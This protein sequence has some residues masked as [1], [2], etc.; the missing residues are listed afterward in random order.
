MQIDIPDQVQKILTKLTDAGYEACVVGGCVRDSVMGL[1]PNDWDVTTSAR[2]DEMKRTL[3]EWKLIETGIRHGTVTVLLDRMP[4][5]VTTFR[6]D[7]PYS[8]G[9]HPDRVFFTQNLKDDLSRRDFTV[10]ALAY[11]PEHGMIDCF[12]GLEDLRNQSIRCVGEPDRRFQEDG[13]RI[14]RALRFSAVLGFSIER[15]TSDSI[16]R[17]AAL[18]DLIAKER[19]RS[20]FMKLLGGKNAVGVLREYRSVFAQFMPELNAMVHFPQNNPYHIYD[21]WEHTLKALEC[22]DG[23]PALRLAVLLHDSGKPLCYTQDENGIGHFHGHGAK[24]RELAGAILRRLRFDR[25]TVDRI[26]TLVEYHDISLP[27][28]KKILL[29]RLNRFGD[30]NLRLLFQIKEA[31]IRAQ[32]PAFLNRLGQLKAAEELFHE[33]LAQKLCFSLKDLAVKG[34]D[35][36]ALGVP[37]GPEVGKILSALLEEVMDGTCPNRR[38]ALLLRAGQ[39]KADGFSV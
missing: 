28:E 11:H 26:T 33:I 37:P 36:I 23:N 27:S 19:I 2:P 21:V 22:T 12:G 1:K 9:R 38:E 29:R 24:S 4:V 5:E 32:N 20:E 34:G 35:L 14:L 30:E 31:D 7:G 39:L 25:D 6:V 3:G 8:D 16:F 18:L 10:N 17:N 15:S 13:L